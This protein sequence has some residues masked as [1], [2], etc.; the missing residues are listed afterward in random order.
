MCGFFREKY[1]NNIVKIQYG[2]T[3]NINSYKLLIDNLF[4]NIAE[5]EARKFGS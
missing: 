3:E 1:R 5:K 4:W 2:N